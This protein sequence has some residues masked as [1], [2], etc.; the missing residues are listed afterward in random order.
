MPKPCNVLILG[1]SRS[2]SA[3]FSFFGIAQELNLF[4]C[5]FKEE[6]FFKLAGRFPRVNP[7]VLIVLSNANIFLFL[8]ASVYFLIQ[9]VLAA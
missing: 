9:T 7:N 8:E 6:H 2:H 3:L 1:S 5:T 4:L